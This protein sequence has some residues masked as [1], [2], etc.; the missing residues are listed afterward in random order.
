LI[1]SF[2]RNIFQDPEF[3]NKQNS[4]IEKFLTDND[5]VITLVLTENLS[6]DSARKIII[7]RNFLARK[8]KLLEI[9][10][11]QYNNTE[12]PRKLKA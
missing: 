11:E 10:G 2:F 3:K 9:N 1:N 7:K 8:N 6:D 12:F 4:K 5:I